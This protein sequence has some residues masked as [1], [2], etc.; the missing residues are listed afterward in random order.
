MEKGEIEIMWTYAPLIFRD[1][2]QKVNL[3]SEEAKFSGI[4]NLIL[5]ALWRKEG[6]VL[7]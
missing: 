1:S 6:D 5:D 2:F 3:E 7:D 4:P